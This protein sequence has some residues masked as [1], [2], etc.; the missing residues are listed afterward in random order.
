M[1]CRK[2]RGTRACYIHNRCWGLTSVTMCCLPMQ[3]MFMTVLLCETLEHC[4]CHEYLC[5]HFCPPSNQNMPNNYYGT[6][7]INCTLQRK[8]CISS[9]LLAL[10]SAASGIL[11]NS[12][13]YN[14]RW[15]RSASLWKDNEHLETVILLEYF[16]F[17]HAR[18]ANP[19]C[20][21]RA[22]GSSFDAL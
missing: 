18:K 16:F 14:T 12:K 6:V 13:L 17:G 21:L 7:F 5:S 8:P 11:E 15:S 3:D 10:L 19:K 2:S 22:V 1:L 20:M 9:L 4:K